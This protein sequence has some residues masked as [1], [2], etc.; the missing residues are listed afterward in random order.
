MSSLD[1]ERRTQSVRRLASTCAGQQEGH[2]GLTIGVSPE[3]GDVLWERLY[4]ALRPAILDPDGLAP[5]LLDLQVPSGCQ[6]LINSQVYLE[7]RRGC[8]GDNR[9]VFL[10]DPAYPKDHDTVEPC[11]RTACVLEGLKS[12]SYSGVKYVLRRIGTNVR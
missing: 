1:P 2:S 10:A 11:R 5:D 12:L 4:S 3:E 7:S 8:S 9:W 6:Y